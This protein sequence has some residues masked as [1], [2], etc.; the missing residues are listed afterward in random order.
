MNLTETTQVLDTAIPVDGLRAHLRLGSGFSEDEL[1][2]DILSSFLRAALSAVEA[3]S[4]KI[5]I[6][7]DF[8]LIATDWRQVCAMPVAP[9]TSI[10]RLGLLTPLTAGETAGVDAEL[11]DLGVMG[12][13]DLSAFQLVK[14]F[15]TPKLRS[16]SANLPTVPTNGGV[17]VEFTAGMATS[18]DELPSDLRQAVLLLAAHYYENRTDVGLPAGCMPFGVSSLIARYRHVRLGLGL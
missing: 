2:D 4:G 7:R 6:E 16:L 18:F 10:S 1:Q 15:Q 12:E 17:F 5:L 9:V 13:L 14:D 11:F 8:Q 3:Q